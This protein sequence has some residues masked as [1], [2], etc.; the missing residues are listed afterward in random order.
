MPT[1]LLPVPETHESITRP[2]AFNAA[3][4]LLEVTGLPKDTS[5]LI[6]GADRQAVMK[7]SKLG[8][9]ETGVNT[10]KQTDRFRI[11][12]TE[13]YL[14]QHALT[15]A[16]TRSENVLVFSDEDL[17]VKIKPAYTH[18]EV[19]LNVQYRADDRQ[20]AER[21]RDDFRA[22]S[23]M[24]R[25]SILHELKYHYP[26]PKEYLV[27]LGHIHQLREAQAGYGEDLKQWFAQ[28]FT[29][30][31]TGK[32]TQAGT[33]STLAV[34]E[35]QVGVLGRFDF[36]Y[37]P[38]KAERNDDAPSWIINFSYTFTY[39]KP[40]NCIM[41]YPLLVHNQLIS[42]RFR[43]KEHPYD[44]EKLNNHWSLSRY[45]FDDVR[46]AYEW[47]AP[48]AGYR[49]PHWDD[50]LPRHVPLGTTTMFNVMLMVDK[51]DLN[52][53]MSFSDIPDEYE[54][55]PDLLEFIRSEAPW[56][57]LPGESIIHV[58]LYRDDIPLEPEYLTVDSELNIRSTL[59]LDLRRRYHL[60][61]SIVNDLFRLTKRAAEKLRRSGDL[62]L[63][64]VKALHPEIEQRGKLPAI[65]GNN[66]IPL[67]DFKQAAQD[68]KDTSRPHQTNIEITR[69]HIGEFVINAED[70]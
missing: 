42:S 5:I 29:P 47:R 12:V 33:H 32:T 22:R 54:I 69:L 30:R 66:Y 44:F 37:V 70:K 55:D 40:T 58:S 2:V 68:I 28:C 25:D 57:H 20:S 4:Q 43:D 53:V 45:V 31:I 62:F 56:L 50:W 67:K 19:T 52:A 18:V 59:A 7:G 64:I 15:S 6:T 60:R 48:V 27:I 3:R 8:E 26:I 65:I 39:E 51:N 41:E 16:V 34:N 38:E 46:G 49:I 23:S 36:D 21:W 9:E 11:D 17:G 13:T 35:K 1:V 63:R 61:I 14:E 10:F 24:M